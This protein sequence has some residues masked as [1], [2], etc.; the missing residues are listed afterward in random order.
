RSRKDGGPHDDFERAALVD[1]R[2]NPEAPFYRFESFQRRPSLRYATA[3]RMTS[4]CIGCHNNDANSTQRDW[5]VPDVGGVLG[6][7]RPLDRA[8]ARTRGGLRGPFVLMAVVCGALLLLSGLVLV[9]RH[10]RLR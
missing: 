10:R 6:L 3:R 1:L 4:D 9:V 5:N 2:K 7:S 8:V